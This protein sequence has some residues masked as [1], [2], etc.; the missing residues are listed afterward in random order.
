M[1]LQIL[2]CFIAIV[3]FCFFLGVPGKLKLYAGAI[4]AIGWAL[5]LIL[6]EQGIAMGTA[7]FFSSCLV[8][9][10]AQIMARIMRTPVT[11]FIVTGILPLVPGAGMYHIA[12]SI[13]DSNSVMTSY[14]M[15]ETLTVAGMIAVSMIVVS[16][17]FRLLPWGTKKKSN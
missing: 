15:T 3:A 13:I 1:V 4:G 9:L 11:I 17:I 8:C 6:R 2:G 14:Y 5:F 7:T 12:R 10:C 16:S